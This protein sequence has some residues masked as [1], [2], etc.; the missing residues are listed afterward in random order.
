MLRCVYIDDTEKKTAK[1]FSDDE[2]TILAKQ[3]GISLLVVGH[4]TKDGQ[5][6]I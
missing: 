6:A 5:I 3:C 1:S 2:L 4:I